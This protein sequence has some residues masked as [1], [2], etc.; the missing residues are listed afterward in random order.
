MRCAH[1]KN[2]NGFTLVEIAIV[3]IIIGLLIGGTFGGMKLVENMQ[4][5]K[6]VQDLR[7]IE[8]AALTFKDTYGRL[9]GDIVNPAARLPCAIGGDGNRYIGVVPSTLTPPQSQNITSPAVTENTSLWHHLFA[10]D[11]LALKISIPL[12]SDPSPFNFGKGQPKAPISGGYR[13]GST[14]E[15]RAFL[16]VAKAPIAPP[17]SSS[18]S[19]SGYYSC[20]ILESIDRKFD[21]GLAGESSLGKMKSLPCQISNLVLRYNINSLS[22]YL[23]YDLRGF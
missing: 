13:V 22:G 12:T 10:A 5:N 21:D 19:L 20:R 11:L 16:I 14:T 9:P 3:M 17:N 4:V 1:N 18:A 8:S 15:L 2:C 23:V 6:T 7:A